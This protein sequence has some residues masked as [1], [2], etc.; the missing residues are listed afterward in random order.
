MIISIIIIIVIIIVVIIFIIIIIIIIIMHYILIIIL[1]SNYY[2]IIHYQ[3]YSNKI[4]FNS[5]TK[6]AVLRMVGSTNASLPSH[7][8]PLRWGHA[9]ETHSASGSGSFPSPGARLRGFF[10]TRLILTILTEYLGHHVIPR[11]GRDYREFIVFLL[12]Y[13]ITFTLTYGFRLTVLTAY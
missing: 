3:Y 1:Y 6:G 11:R 2:N 12:S 10:C 9:P 4:K 13:I 7:N 5:Q 8:A